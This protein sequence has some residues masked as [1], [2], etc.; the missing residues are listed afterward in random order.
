MKLRTYILAIA[1]VHL[2]LYAVI[3]F[4]TPIIRQLFAFSY[5]LFIPG[6]VFLGVLKIEKIS[7]LDLVSYS[8]GLSIA[9]VMFVG[10]FVNQTFPTL[11]IT[12]PLSTTPILLPISGFT[13]ILFVVGCRRG[14]AGIL[15]SMTFDELGQIPIAK[16]VILMLLPVVGVVSVLY[17][18]EAIPLL[19]M[20]I[21]ALFVIC[22]LSTNLIPVK[23]YP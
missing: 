5:L 12:Q 16:S 20:A 21:A 11:G 23:L 15:G 7:L 3:G 22:S 13:L 1:S 17:V 14:I 10:L 19:P 2:L 18:K 9:F 6:F 8:I 4:D